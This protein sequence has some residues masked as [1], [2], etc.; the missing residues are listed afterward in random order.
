MS[1]DNVITE[2]IDTIDTTAQ[3]DIEQ[4]LKVSQEE[5]KTEIDPIEAAVQERLAQMKSNMDRMVKERDIA[6]KKAAEIEQQQKQEKLKRLEEEGKIQEAL[7]I[8][9]A[10]A[11]A[12]LKVYEEE[13][14]RLNRDNIVNS[15]LSSLDFR[16]DR[17]RQLAY[18]DIVDELTRNE[19][20]SWVHKSGISIQDYIASY[21][22]NEENN[23]LFK[24]KPNSGTGAVSP[25]GAPN[26]TE[27]KSISQ[28]TTDEV[29][30]MAAR[31]QLG[32]FN[33]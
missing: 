8:K 25:T 27:K 16:N 5:T 14:T 33:Y 26:T 2:E 19:D 7:E 31:G 22:K 1:Q 6:L 12:K 21:S 15:A 29:L 9:L 18:R 23:F 4:E 20:G 28:M 10:E 32:S 3:E 11:D 17:S 13:N 24:V 30:A